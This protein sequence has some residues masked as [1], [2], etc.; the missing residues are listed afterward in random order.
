MIKVKQTKND[1][2]ISRLIDYINEYAGIDIT[3]KCRQRH[4]VLSR[5]VY[6]KIA[7]EYIPDTLDNIAS[8]V[9]RDHSTAIHAKKIFHEIEM[10]ST[11][12][13]MYNDACAYMDFIDGVALQEYKDKIESDRAFLGEQ[14]AKL[15]D[16]I[17]NQRETLLRQK[18]LL[19]DIGLEDH[20][21]QYRDLPS[22]KKYIFK[23]RVNAILK[24]I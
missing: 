9:N 16:V 7:A 24:M 19:D 11:Y 15:N 20:E 22:E 21:I 5:T 13:S 17:R 23:E 12:K 14:I 10:Y 4:Y 3:D 2:M 8:A 6:F 1:I 18:K